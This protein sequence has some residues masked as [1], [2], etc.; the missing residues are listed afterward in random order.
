MFY[1]QPI[2]YFP[3]RAGHPTEQD[4]PHRISTRLDPEAIQINHAIK[5]ASYLPKI[6]GAREKALIS[7]IYYGK[8]ND[9]L[10]LLPPT[11]S[12]LLKLKNLEVS[13]H[14]NRS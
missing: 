13:N 4:T 6:G 14:V 2:T 8:W 11:V 9:G 1:F 3:G 12:D 5:T 10:W 7:N